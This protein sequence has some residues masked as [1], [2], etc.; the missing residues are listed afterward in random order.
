[1]IF[2]AFRYHKHFA[3]QV[4]ADKDK[5]AKDLVRD[6]EK[7]YDAIEW[8]ADSI[9]NMSEEDVKSLFLWHIKEMGDFKQRYEDL[10]R[11]DDFA[12]SLKDDWYFNAEIQKNIDHYI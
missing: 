9:P 2:Y 1:M 12:K 8:R 10:S 7:H 4:Q 3:D 5:E 11:Y 6:I